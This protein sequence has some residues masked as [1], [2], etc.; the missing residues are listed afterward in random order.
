MR[1]II[2]VP[3]MDNVPARFAQSLTTLERTGDVMLAWE[4]GSLIY[5]A[6]NK[7]V[8]HAIKAEADRILWLDSDMVFKPDLLRRLEASGKDF[9][10]GLYFRRVPPFTPVLFDR[11]EISGE[12][13]TWTEFNTIPDKPFMVGGCGF[14]GVLMS[15]DVVMSV[16]NKFKNCFA[17]IGGI[18]E[19]LAFCWRARQCGYE[20]WCDPNAEMGHCGNTIITRSIWEGVKNANKG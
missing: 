18:G 14:G 16:Q 12:N 8:Q 10:T 7:L 5:E 15:M 13:C 6:R 1:T 9:V 11:F 19:D 4:V 2:A 17:P 3:S 20:I